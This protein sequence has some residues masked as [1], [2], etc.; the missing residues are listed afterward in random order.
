[1]NRIHYIYNYENTKIRFR[2]G[3]IFSNIQLYT[4]GSKSSTFTDLE[5]RFGEITPPK[6]YLRFIYE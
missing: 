2:N 1:M 4:D 5:K 6:F 3:I